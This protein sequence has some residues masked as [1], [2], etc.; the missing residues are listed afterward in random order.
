MKYIISVIPAPMEP[1]SKEILFFE[2]E[3]ECHK[4]MTKNEA[5]K[6]KDT[7]KIEIDAD[8]NFYIISP[9]DKNVEIWN[10]LIWKGGILDFDIAWWGEEFTLKI[11]KSKI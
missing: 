8:Y 4:E 11:F 3:M 2:H 1:S 6:Q 5:L 9:S 10:C 7:F